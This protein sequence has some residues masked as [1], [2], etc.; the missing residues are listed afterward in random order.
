MLISMYISVNEY[1]DIFLLF[2]KI[3]KLNFIHKRI[4]LKIKKKV[5]F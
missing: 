4:S 1:D 5:N 2:K 3:I